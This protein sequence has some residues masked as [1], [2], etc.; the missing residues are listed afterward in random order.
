MLRI[1]ASILMVL[2]V[3]GYAQEE[4]RGTIVVKKSA[5]SALTEDSGLVYTKAQQNPAFPGGY[6][7]MLKFINKNL[8][9]PAAEKN[10]GI[11]GTV[12]LEFV[13]NE[14]GSITGG[15]VTRGVPG[16]PGLDKEALRLLSIMPKW[17]PGADYFNKIQAKRCYLPI[18]F[19]L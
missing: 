4:K 13:V 18:K 1:F 7:E 12:Q 17:K 16:G 2:T 15:R 3:S 8:Q 6:S 9:Y 10:A 14:D 11:Q 19:K 5:K